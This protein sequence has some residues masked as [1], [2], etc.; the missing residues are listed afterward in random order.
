MPSPIT[1]LSQSMK[2][3]KRLLQIHSDVGGTDQ[4]RRYGL[5][6]LNKSGV[7]FVSAAW[8]AFVEDTAIQAIDHIL[9]V[10]SDHLSLPLPMRKAAAKAL[11][12][13]RNELKVWDLAGDGWK[14]VA[15]NYRDELIR[16]EISTFNTPKPHN[17]NTLFHKLL[18]I[19]KISSHWYWQGMSK[20]SAYSKLKGFIETRG[21]IAH[22]GSLTQSI[23]KDYVDGH[24]KFINRIAVRTSNVVCKHI[25]HQVGSFP[26]L[27]ARYGNFR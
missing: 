13:D 8:E 6:V 22:Q 9:D 19:D 1:N 4:G 26:W 11:E 24:R 18:G 2:D 17:V 27:P 23:T 10:A 14:I 15:K 12:K 3:A 20:A 16:D 25:K 5:D 7:L 21:A